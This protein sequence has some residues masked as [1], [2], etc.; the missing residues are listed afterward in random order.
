MDGAPLADPVEE[1]RRLIALAGSRGLRLRALGGVAICLQAPDGKPRLARAVKD[2][3][4]AVARGSGRATSALLTQAGYRAD[5]MFNALR[6][7]RR[8]LFQDLVHSRHLDVF[9]GSFSMCHE[10]PLAARL[11]VILSSCRSKNSC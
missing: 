6:G 3:D 11:A 8:M 2:I 1:A 9:V 4:V 7:S 5:E 10:I